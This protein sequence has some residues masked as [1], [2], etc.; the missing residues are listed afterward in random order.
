MAK[1]KTAARFINALDGKTY[2]K[3]A[4]IELSDVDAEYFK[5]HKLVVVE[6]E[7]KK[8]EPKKK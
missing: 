6:K 7:A 3:G 5:I 4:D 2:E 8:Q 1:Y